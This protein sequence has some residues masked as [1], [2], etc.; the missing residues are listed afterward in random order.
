M[1]SQK[2]VLSTLG[3]VL[4]HSGQLHALAMDSMLGIQPDMEKSSHPPDLPLNS[5]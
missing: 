2:T 1:P 3:G 4:G 5:H